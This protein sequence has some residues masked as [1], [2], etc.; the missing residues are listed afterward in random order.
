MPCR[1][2]IKSLDLNGARLAVPHGGVDLALV[3]VRHLG[4]TLEH[5]F[6]GGAGQVVDVCGGEALGGDWW[7]DWLLC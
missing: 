1:L 7:E 6:P 2:K 4:E 3:L 5:G